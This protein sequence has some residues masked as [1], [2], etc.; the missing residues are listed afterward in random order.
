MSETVHNHSQG[1]SAEQ[2]QTALQFLQRT[3]LQGAEAP[4]FVNLLAALTAIAK[5]PAPMPAG[6]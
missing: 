1:L 5:S 2:A 4:V 6:E 3:Q